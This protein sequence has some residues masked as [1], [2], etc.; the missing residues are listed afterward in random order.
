MTFHYQRKRGLSWIEYSSEYRERIN[1]HICCRVNVCTQTIFS[2]CVKNVKSILDFSFVF[3]AQL[4]IWLGDSGSQIVFWQ[5]PYSSAVITFVGRWKVVELQTRLP[6]ALKWSLICSYIS[7]LEVFS[8]SSVTENRVNLWCLGNKKR[9]RKK[10]F[11][12]LREL[13][14]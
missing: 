14:S 2:Q 6:W 12:I 10:R 5:G 11:R 13:F 1:I 3:S 9:E 8:R 4:L 7:K